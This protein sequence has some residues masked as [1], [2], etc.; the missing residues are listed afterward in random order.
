MLKRGGLLI[1]V[2][3]P[4]LIVH[5]LEKMFI[6]HF[7]GALEYDLVSRY[8]NEPHV[9]QEIALGQTSGKKKVLNS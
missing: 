7:L 3:K 9:T 6:Y 5:F 8:Q 1:N 4:H 2:I